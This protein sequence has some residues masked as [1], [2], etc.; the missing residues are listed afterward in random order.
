MVKSHTSIYNNVI[1]TDLR[2]VDPIYTGNR[3]I[4]YSL[5]PEQNVSLWIVDG[6]QKQ[7]VSIA[8]GYSILNR[9]CQVD[10]GQLMLKYGGGG[11]KM[12]GTCQVPYD[13][14]ETIIQEI[15]NVLKS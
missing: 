3:F 1:V 5:F 2:D 14:A 15:V 7:N 9:S 10:I 11:H 6:K 13:D 8:C 12:V 4:V